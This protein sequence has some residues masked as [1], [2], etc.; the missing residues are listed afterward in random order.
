ML[1][2]GKRWYSTTEIDQRIGIST[3]TLYR[4]IQTLEEAGFVVERRTGQGYRLAAEGG[5][6]LTMKRLL[7]FTEEEAMLIYRT[8]GMLQGEGPARERL[9][10]K[11]HTLYDCRMLEGAHRQHT[12][13]IVTQLQKAIDKKLQVTLTQYRSNHSLTIQ[14]RTVEPFAFTEQYDAVWAYDA[15][16][17][18]CKQ[19]KIA[20]MEGV[21]LNPQGWTAE[22]RHHIP[23]TDAFGFAAKK[24]MA[25][26]RL[27]LSLRAA[28]L[29]REEYPLSEKYITHTNNEYIAILPFANYKGIGRFIKGLS[30]EITIMAPEGLKK[31]VRGDGS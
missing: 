30:D 29:L 14:D 1:L 2:A 21:Q 6:M 19:F 25:T 18:T 24:P 20:R 11:L 10:R 5:S 8:L 9:M 12:L 16:D 7:H 15:A 26:A 13:E 3:R 28:N 31:Y 17:R 22:P 4:Y 27:Q 23:F